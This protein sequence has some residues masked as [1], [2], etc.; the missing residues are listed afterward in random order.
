VPSAEEGLFEA[1]RKQ[2]RPHG[3]RSGAN[4]RAAL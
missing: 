1:L 3:D 2:R 4:A